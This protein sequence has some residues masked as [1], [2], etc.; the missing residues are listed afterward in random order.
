M[1]SNIKLIIIILLF[2][3]CEAKQNIDKEISKYPALN[4]LTSLEVC[5]FL[6][7]KYLPIKKQ[8]SCDQIAKSVFLLKTIIIL[9]SYE[10]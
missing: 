10:T 7:I 5:S 4:C 6:P 9:I 2:F 8:K 1:N 3:S